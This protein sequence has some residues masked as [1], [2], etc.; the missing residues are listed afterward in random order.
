M[1][2]NYN[3][4]SIENGDV[5]VN[6]ENAN[7]DLKHI[8]E[9]FKKEGFDFSKWYLI[10]ISSTESKRVYCFKDSDGH[11]VDML[12]G[13][14]NQVTPNYFKNHDSYKYSL[15]QA[16]SIRE[17]IRLYEAMYSPGV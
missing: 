14:N 11:Y 3:L 7:Y 2:V 17:A 6:V 12:I 16:K 13:E 4:K 15:F 10:E 5:K 1:F 8:M 9:C